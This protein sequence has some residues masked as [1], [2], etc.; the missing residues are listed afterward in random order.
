MRRRGRTRS[1]S[2]PPP[3]LHFP[4]S[5]CS[6]GLSPRLPF[7]HS[8]RASPHSASFWLCGASRLRASR[9]ASPRP[10]SPP[11]AAPGSPRGH[12]P[13]LCLN[14]AE[15]RVHAAGGRITRRAVDSRG[16]A[17]LATDAM[18]VSCATV[19]T[20]AAHLAA[21]LSGDVLRVSTPATAPTL[22]SPAHWRA[23]RGSR[24]TDGRARTHVA[25]NAS[26]AFHPKPAAP[27]G[28]ARTAPGHFALAHLVLAHLARTRSLV[29]G[30]LWRSQGQA[31][32][33]PV[34]VPGHQSC[35]VTG[36]LEMPSVTAHHLLGSG[37]SSA[38]PANA[39][40]ASVAGPWPRLRSGALAPSTRPANP[41]SSRLASLRAAR[42]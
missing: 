3:T 39:T 24:R 9:T 37:S 6:F 11:P 26:G 4:S 30:R 35:P 21:R 36:V 8:P 19:E 41:A 34:S 29:F 2:R 25:F 1:S 10:G 42:S 23:I 18:S 14:S 12:V 33:V 15:I 27:P 5:V 40:R 13:C 28:P 22:H 16:F 20:S 32:A 7:A 17:A 31:I 38:S